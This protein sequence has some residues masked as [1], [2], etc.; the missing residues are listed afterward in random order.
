MA[1]LKQPLAALSSRFLILRLLPPRVWIP[2]VSCRVCQIWWQLRALSREWRELLD[3]AESSLDS[4][5][6]TGVGV[7]TLESRVKFV[8]YGYRLKDDSYR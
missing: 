7:Q 4:P 3:H 8:S 6:D 5:E 2:A 1:Q